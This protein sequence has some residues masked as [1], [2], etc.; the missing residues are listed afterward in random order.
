M[1]DAHM[2]IAVE[3]FGKSS[4]TYVACKSSSLQMSRLDCDARNKIKFK[5]ITMSTDIYS[6]PQL[7]VRSDKIYQQEIKH[8]KKHQKKHKQEKFVH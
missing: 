6:S 8:S 3:L 2:L 4:S 7:T 5:S 1:N